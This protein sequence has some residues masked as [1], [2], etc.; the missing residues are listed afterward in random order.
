MSKIKQATAIESTGIVIGNSKVKRTP[1][2]SASK[3]DTVIS[4]LKRSKGATMPELMEVTGWQR[5]SVHGMLSGAIKK[6]LQLPLTSTKEARGQVYRIAAAV[7]A[8]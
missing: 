5:H 3:Q 7:T 4:L 6:R 1:A 8:A 2:P